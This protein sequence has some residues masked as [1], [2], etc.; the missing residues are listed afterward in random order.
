MTRGHMMF[1]NRL[2]LTFR[3][4][5]DGDLH[6]GAGV[7]EADGSLLDEK[8]RKEAQEK[9][10]D[11]PLVALAQRNADGNAVIPATSL[12][13]AL[14]SQSQTP[15]SDDQ[16]DRLLG[17]AGY[18]ERDDDGGV[19][20]VRGRIGRLWLGCA[21]AEAAADNGERFA[22][23]T[24]Q[25]GTRKQGFVKTAVRIDRKSG[26]AED[27]LLYN[28]EMIGAGAIFTA[29]ATLFLDDEDQEALIGLLAALLAPL[30]RD[31]GLAIGGQQRQ[32]GAR[33]RLADDGITATR[34]T[35]NADAL[36]LRDEDAA[37][38][39]RRIADK[40]SGGARE[41]EKPI[42][43]T[44][45]CDGPF[46]SVRGEASGTDQD[47]NKREVTQP[48]TDLGGKPR[49]WPSSLLGALRARAAW[50]AELQRLRGYPHGH[51]FAPGLDSARGETVNDRGKVVR[52]Q[53]EVA[54]LSSVERLFGVAGWRGLI[55]ITRLAA[56]DACPIAP[57]PMTSV[58]IDRFTGGARDQRLFTEQTF[59]H[60]RFDCELRLEARA[61]HLL[62][63]EKQDAD[64]ALFDLLLDDI[65]ESG[66]EL[67]HGA[68]KG[69]G[70][71]D[72]TVS[73][74]GEERQ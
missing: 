2:E 21:I 74:P 23:A 56:A 71:F 55:S 60:S 11:P 64:R 61:K 15:L 25:G 39:A 36:A 37:D 8:A 28:R 62:D 27:K 51:D 47:G 14:R 30:A 59:T 73:R 18:V 63:K 19:R 44:L 57:L 17:E 26:A 16:F 53:K 69:F 20:T 29:K 9:G 13:G 45:T 31:P 52:Q 32:A 24:R 35:I 33:L 10:E 70:W 50:L 68:A 7:E 42:R 34:R 65:S 3:L 43:L 54:R 72:V 6:I 38:I 58:S 41:D 46:I 49:L 5:L 40:A 1:G 4:R 48:L 12:K 67:G 66:L 22:G